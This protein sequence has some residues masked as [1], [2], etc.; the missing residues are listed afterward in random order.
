M[1]K[2]RSAIDYDSTTKIIGAIAATIGA[3][4]FIY[5]FSIGKRSRMRE[6]YNFAKDFIDEVGSN[7]DIHPYVREKGIKPPLATGGS[8]QIKWNI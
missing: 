3:G 1:F 6:K 7:D 4:K 5:D 8:A 2:N